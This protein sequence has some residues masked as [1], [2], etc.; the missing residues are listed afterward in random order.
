MWHIGAGYSMPLAK[1][2][3]GKVGAGY[4]AATEKLNVIDNNRKGKEMGYEFN[5]NLNYNILKGLDFGVYAAYAVVGDFF[6]STLPNAQ[7]PDDVYDVHFRL[8]Y[9]F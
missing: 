6:Q 9:A 7:D 2:L 4:L 1:Q 3:T 5:A 8:N